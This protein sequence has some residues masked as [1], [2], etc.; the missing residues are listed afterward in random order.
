MQLSI[1]WKYVSAGILALSLLAPALKL[2]ALDDDDNGQQ[3]QKPPVLATN[4]YMQTNLVSNLSG[5]APV[6]DPNLINPWG[7][8]RSSGGPWWVSDNN[9]GLSTLYSGAGSILPLVV[10]VPTASPNST[11]PGSPTGIVFNGS[12]DFAL[13]SGNPA[14]FLFATED[15]TISGWNPN[16]NHTKAMIVVNQGKKSVFKG[17]TIATVNTAQY[18][19]HSFLYAADF[20]QGRIEVFNSY[21]QRVPQMEE[22]FDADGLPDG[23][24]PFNIQNL[25]GNLYVTYAKQDA[26]KLNE[27]DGSGLGFVRVYSPEGRRLMDLHTEGWL[28]APWGLAI[29]PSDFGPYSHDILVGNF[30][31]GWIAVFD[32]QTGKFLDYLRDSKGN[33]VWIDGLWALAP[34]NGTANAGSATS[35]YF[36]AGSNHEQGG[37]FGTLT[38]LQNPQGGDQ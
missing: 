34:G 20:R 4:Q 35:I 18:G 32:P 19:T 37:L 21:F 7:L 24:A 15:G 3:N 30:G 23:Y 9:S 5:M 12:M 28:N 31:S 13:S 17:A 27:I 33:L 6:T 38:A 29:A 16:V 8:A 25:G 22:A 11:Q 1:K 14:I 2:S 10:T 36:S 26:A